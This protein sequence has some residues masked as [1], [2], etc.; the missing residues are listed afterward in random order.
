[1]FHLSAIGMG[2]DAGVRDYFT[3]SGMLVWHAISVARY[4]DKMQ[5]ADLTVPCRRA[6]KILS[7]MNA[8]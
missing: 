4:V 1:M 6:H 2:S 5:V 8:E 7:S 3:D